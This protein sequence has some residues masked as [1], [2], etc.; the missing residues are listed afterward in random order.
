MKKVLVLMGGDSPEH[1]VSILSGLC[2]LENIDRNKY[3]VTGSYID[4]SGNFYLYTEEK[5]DLKIG[6]KLTGLKKIDNII[7]FL[8]KYDII[9]PVLHGNFGE[10]GKVQ[11]LLEFI[12]KP[13]VGLKVLGSALGMDK[14]YSKIIFEKAGIKQ[15]K[16]IFIKH[17]NDKY[18]Y[19]DKQFNEEEYSYDKLLELIKKELNYPLFIKPSNSGSSIGISKVNNDTE[20]KKAIDL[21]T[22]YDYKILI[23]EGLNA[24]ELEC[25]V[26]EQEKVIASK[27]G[28][29]ISK[30]NFYDYDSKYKNNSSKIIINPDLPEEIEKKI[31]D[32]AIKAFKAIDGKSLSRIDFFLDKDNNI[33]LNEINTMP[34]FTSISMY[35]KLFEESGIKI[36][37]LLTDLIETA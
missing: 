37:D 30:D 31:Q 19:I 27:V 32:I 2:V 33:Y 16:H 6:D 24:R 10:D 25:G 26:L 5:Y 12:K 29:I 20:L 35:P 14:A 3:E 13:Y 7:D 15:V 9:F 22:E 23:E 36:S 18:I 17:I 21:A 34:G 1:E 4:R 28:E 11:G 8:K